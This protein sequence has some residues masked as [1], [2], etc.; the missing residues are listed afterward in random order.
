VDTHAG[1]TTVG[2]DSTGALGEPLGWAANDATNDPAHRHGR[3]LGDGL[4]GDLEPGPGLGSPGSLVG[5][6]QFRQVGLLEQFLEAIAFNH[7]RF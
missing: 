5:W 3:G 6:S 7:L 2:L 1:F 4:V